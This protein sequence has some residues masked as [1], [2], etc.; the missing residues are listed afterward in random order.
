MNSLFLITLHVLLGYHIGDATGPGS[1]D[2]FNSLKVSTAFLCPSTK[3]IPKK[4]R[5][6][7]FIF[8]PSQQKAYREE[9]DASSF[10]SLSAKK[11]GYQFGDITKGLINSITGES[12]YK[13][14]DLSKHLD[15][16]AK[17]RVAQLHNKTT[18]EFG[19]L[20]RYLDQSSKQKKRRLREQE[21]GYFGGC[22]KQH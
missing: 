17:A 10:W 6:S 21:A 5:P 16:E 11:K 14:G 15:R 20:A 22:P 4:S 12:E 19:D 3:P 9:V 13:F 8:L 2:H 1:G 18:Y 7:H